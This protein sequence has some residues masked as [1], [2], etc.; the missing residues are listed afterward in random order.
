MK[1]CIAMIVAVV[2]DLICCCATADAVQYQYA[3]VITQQGPLNM[4]ETASSKSAIVI[5]IPNHTYIPV[6]PFDAVWCKGWYNGLEG[7][8]MTEFLSFVDA[9]P[10]KSLSLN[11]SGQ[12]VLELNKRLQELNYFSAAAKPTDN[13]GA[14]TE[15]RIK[16]FQSTNG[17]E[18]TG[19]VTPELQALLFWGPVEKN[20]SP[21]PLDPD[22]VF[23]VGPSIKPTSSATATPMPAPTP[24]AAETRTMTVNVSGTCSNYNHVGNSW[25]KYYSINGSKVSKGDTID[26]TLGENVVLYAKITEKDSS[27]DVGTVKETREITQDDLD[28]GFTVTKKVSVREDN[29]RYAGNKAVWTVTFKF[30]P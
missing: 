29:G 12:D 15:A 1:K 16:L 5:K 23:P 30:V 10:F 26:I 6:T 19:N 9:L 8:V 2:L 25:S 3:Q 7:Y 13:F 11:D 28:N 27:P 22:Y 20:E 14:D 24:P 4:R 21:D 17:M 18:V